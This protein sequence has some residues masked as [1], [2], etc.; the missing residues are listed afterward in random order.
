MK[1]V[2]LTDTFYCNKLVNAGT[3]VESGNNLAKQYPRVFAVVGANSKDKEPETA[4]ADNPGSGIT[5][6]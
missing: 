6:N 4:K 2:T 3:V 1:F 5:G